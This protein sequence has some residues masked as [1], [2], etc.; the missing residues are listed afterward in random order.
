[1]RLKAKPPPR[2]VVKVTKIVVDAK[3]PRQAKVIHDDRVLFTIRTDVSGM[4][5]SIIVVAQETLLKAMEKG[6]TGMI[7][8]NATVGLD[9][10]NLKL[11]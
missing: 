11:H 8:W 10:R 9:T 3:D 2:K 6:K 4:H 5:P 1:M 7:L